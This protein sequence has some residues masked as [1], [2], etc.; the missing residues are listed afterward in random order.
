MYNFATSFKLSVL[1]YFLLYG[2]LAIWKGFYLTIFIV[3]YKRTNM[4]KS[5]INP[6]KRKPS[7]ISK[8]SR[9]VSKQ[10]NPLFDD[11]LYRTYKRLLDTKGELLI[12]I[13]VL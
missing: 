3:S 9:N 1:I 12:V 10:H 11:S 6:F 13:A 7:R 2:A 8:G 4:D 5:V